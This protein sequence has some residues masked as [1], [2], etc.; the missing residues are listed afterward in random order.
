MTERTGNKQ[1]TLSRERAGSVGTLDD[2]LKRKRE[3]HEKKGKEEELFKK[4]K[5]TERTPVKRGETKEEGDME[6]V[7][8]EFKEE[9]KELRELKEEF[10]VVQELKEELKEIQKLKESF[11]EFR[12]VT[13]EIK[14]LKDEWVKEKEVWHK[15]RIELKNVIKELDSKMAYLENQS[16]RDNIVIRG[17]AG[18]R[19][20]SWNDC[21]LKVVE[22]ARKIGVQLSED[23]VIRA[24]RTGRGAHP[25][26]IVAKLSSWKLKEE[27]MKNKRRLKGTD[28]FVMEDFAQR[29]IDE[30]RKLF[31]EAKKRRDQGEEAFVKFDK[32]ILE[33]GVFKWD[34]EKDQLYKIQERSGRIRNQGDGKKCMETER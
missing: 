2:F 21:S 8:K 6:A 20:E 22:I 31:E 11:H 25:R 29:T 13:E 9:L 16:R 15:E 34:W 33:D 30:R 28:V 3:E 23:N 26:P 18:Q 4:S 5:I 1:I 14:K 27:F 7:L 17:V 10:R 19:G 12:K 32:L 24:H